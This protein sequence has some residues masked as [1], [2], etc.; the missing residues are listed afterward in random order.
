MFH[1]NREHG[2]RALQSRVPRKIFRPKTKEVK[3]AQENCI[4]R[5][6]TLYTLLQILLG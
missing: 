4:L 6:F 5:N 3:E 2:Q 1:T